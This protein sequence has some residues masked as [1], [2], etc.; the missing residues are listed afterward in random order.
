MSLPFTSLRH[1]VSW[2]L[3]LYSATWTSLLTLTVAVASFSPEVAFV[4]TIS[5]FSRGCEQEGTVRVPLDVPG[6]ALVVAVSA[7]VVRA[8]GLWEDDEATL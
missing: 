4:S 1:R 3:I 8:V 5:S 7:W 6:R 2:P